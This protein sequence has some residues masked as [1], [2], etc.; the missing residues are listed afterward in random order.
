[1]LLIN[2]DRGFLLMVSFLMAV[3]VDV[4]NVE[5]KC[6]LADRVLFYPL[7]NSSKLCNKGGKSQIIPAGGFIALAKRGQ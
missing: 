7:D 1:M 5:I 6:E 2:G 3:F 4:C